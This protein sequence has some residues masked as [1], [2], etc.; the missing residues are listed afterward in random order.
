LNKD[1]TITVLANE[2]EFSSNNEYY[3]Q[4]Y[5]VLKKYKQNSDKISLNFVDLAVNP[6]FANQYQGKDHNAGDILVTCGSSVDVLTAE[7][8]FD[9][10]YSYGSYGSSITASKAEQALTSAI[11]NVTSDKKPLIAFITGHN[12]GDSSGLT[13]ILE[14]NGYQTSDVSL[15][16]ESI[17]QDTQVAV[18]VAP[19][20]DLTQDEINK[21]QT[22]LTNNGSYGK[23]LI[24]FASVKQNTLPNLEDWLRTWGLSVDAGA[25]VETNSN[26]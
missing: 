3:K 2:S 4:A 10:Q 20:N 7:D 26:R 22:Y 5:E 17:P 18:F 25:V 19:E 6:T 16:T 14:K 24:Y 13:S 1:V 9:I 11:L 12:E 21:L 23:H 15:L 8:L